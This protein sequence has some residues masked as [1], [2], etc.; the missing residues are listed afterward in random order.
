[1]ETV[2]IMEP[3]SEESLDSQI[4]QLQN[5]VNRLTMLVILQ[6]QRPFLPPYQVSERVPV[7]KKPVLIFPF[8]V[9]D[10][11]V[12]RFVKTVV[13][14]WIMRVRNVLGLTKQRT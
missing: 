5:S 8:T 12:E 1:M 14:R 10:R 7:E 9:L 2:S 3:R 13:A 6:Q 4:N 11:T